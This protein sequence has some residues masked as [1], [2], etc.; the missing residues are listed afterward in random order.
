MFFLILPCSTQAFVLGL[1]S[2]DNTVQNIV[3]IEKTYQLY[4]PIVAFIYDPWEKQDVVAELEKMKAELGDQRI[5]HISVS[6]NQFSAEEVANGAFDEQYKLFF[7][8]IKRLKLKVVFRTM[9]EMNGGRYPWGSN[10]E[11]FKKAWIHVWELSRSLGLSQQDILFDFSVNHWDMPTLWKPSQQAKLIQ[12]KALEPVKKEIETLKKKKKLT[13][14]EQSLLKN[15]EKELKKLK[16]CPHFEDYFPGE[17]YVDLVGITF[18]NRG[19][20][21]SNRLWRSPTAILNDPERKTLERAQKLGKPL[22]IDEVGTTAVRYGESYSPQNSRNEFLSS[23]SDIR[24][25]QWLRALSELLKANH[26]VGAVYFNVDYTNGLN[27]PLVWEADWAIINT[28]IGKF[29]EGFWDLYSS[30]KSDFSSLLALFGLG[31][32]QVNGKE[33]LVPQIASKDIQQIEGLVNEK[34]TDPKEKSDLYSKLLSS[35]SGKIS[36]DK[37]IE[38]LAEEYLE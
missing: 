38:V 9:H 2:T 28:T 31:K 25:N 11:M 36:F 14:E 24:K 15:K 13:A 22:F 8:T 26:F 20:A 1:K 30:S 5:Y 4:L 27:F 17:A 21:T 37:A 6:P 32:I 23:W 16:S 10:P 34:I 29:Y 7:Q 12:C 35:P 19:K 3:D 18:Y 33:R